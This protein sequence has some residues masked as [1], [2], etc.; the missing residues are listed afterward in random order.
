M[1]VKR[2]RLYIKTK[3]KIHD[4][5]GLKEH[6]NHSPQPHSLFL[7][8]SQILTPPSPKHL[9]SISNNTHTDACEKWDVICVA[10]N[11]FSVLFIFL[12]NSNVNNYHANEIILH[13]ERQLYFF[14][15][16]LLRFGPY[17]IHGLNLRSFKISLRRII[18]R[19]TH[20]A[21]EQALRPLRDNTQHSH[22]TDIHAVGWILSGYSQYK[23]NKAEENENKLAVFIIISE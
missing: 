7:N 11:I 19:R 3:R 17:S 23:H 2:I 8:L 21:S 5:L 4:Y 22:G 20:H 12:L 15:S 16:F 9:T 6:S 10:V 14:L 1:S 18:S 13:S